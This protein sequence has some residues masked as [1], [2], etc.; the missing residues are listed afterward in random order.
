M[1]NCCLPILS[2]V[3]E[4][5][6]VDDAYEKIYADRDLFGL[7]NYSK[8]S[9]FYDGCNEKVIGK[10]KDEM[11]G[12]VVSEFVGLKS[13]MYSLVTVDDEEKTMAKGVNKKLRYS[14]FFDVLFDK[15]TVRHNMKRI[16][17]KRHRLDKYD[18]CK[19]SLSCF[20]DKRYVLG[21]GV[22]TLE[23]FQKDTV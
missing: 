5:R 17:A 9:K 7:S 4:I 18:V 12:S 3:Y 10:M 13:K 16:Q 21:D 8:E 20:D 1:L 15:K 22:N 11:G 19:V 23:Y 6:G 2:L 14:E